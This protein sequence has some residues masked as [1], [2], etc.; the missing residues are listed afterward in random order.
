VTKTL[1]KQQQTANRRG[2]LSLQRTPK[3]DFTVY[4]GYL[5]QGTG[6]IQIYS[7]AALNQTMNKPL[8]RAESR[9]TEA[10]Y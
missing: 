9:L 5:V 2:E 1:T 4:S 6:Y 8:W 3:S 10:D 7:N